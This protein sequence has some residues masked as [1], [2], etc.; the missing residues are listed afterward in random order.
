MLRQIMKGLFFFK[1]V[2]I[3]LDYFVATFEFSHP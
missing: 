1:F 2:K 3:L